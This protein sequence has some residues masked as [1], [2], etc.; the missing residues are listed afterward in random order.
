[1]INKDRNIIYIGFQNALYYYW[2]K[3]TRHSSYKLENVLQ[4]AENDG[5]THYRISHHPKGLYFLIKDAL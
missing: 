1:M 2:Y 5:F 4:S 3:G